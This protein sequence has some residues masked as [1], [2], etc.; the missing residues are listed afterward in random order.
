MLASVLEITF[1]LLT[2]TP[3]SPALP[4]ESSPEAFFEPFE[5]VGICA[6]KS[7]TRTWSVVWHPRA[8]GS[9]P[10]ANRV[11]RRLEAPDFNDCLALLIESD[12]AT[13]EAVLRFASEPTAE[14][15]KTAI[16]AARRRWTTYGVDR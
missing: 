4:I 15:A 3:G 1:S 14:N 13:R 6:V 16:E 8:T 10:S 9:D 5:L 7:E 12:D 2:T 11:F